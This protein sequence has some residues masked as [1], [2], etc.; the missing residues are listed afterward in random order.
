MTRKGDGTWTVRVPVPGMVPST[1]TSVK[2]WSPAAGAV[3]RNRVTDPYS[4]GLTT[5]SARSLMIDLSDPSLAP[6]GWSLLRP[7]PIA[8]P[9]DRNIYE[10]HIRDFSIGDDTVPAAHRGTYWPSPTALGGHDAPEAR[11]PTRA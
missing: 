7:P 4:V 11:L 1:C 10:L 5:N 3:V 6:P 9:E 2:V 8:Q